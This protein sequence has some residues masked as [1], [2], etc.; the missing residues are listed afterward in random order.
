MGSWI[1]AIC[2]KS[3]G[4]LHEID[5]AEALAD[6]DFER[7]AVVQ[8]LHE[9]VG[10]AAEE[11]LRFEYPK[12]RGQEC[13]LLYCVPGVD[14][15]IRFDRWIGPQARE[16]TEEMLERVKGEGPGAERVRAV[17]AAAVETIGFEL[18]VSDVVGMGFNIALAAAMFIAS[19]GYGLVQA[20]HHGDTWF[21]PDSS[22]EILRY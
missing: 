20:D 12:Q 16:E 1:R 4:P 18:K 7:W 22:D 21:D 11:A 8:G 15:Y 2:T 9:A 17:L 3:V 5:L 10:S 13:G 14:H 6:C 19:A